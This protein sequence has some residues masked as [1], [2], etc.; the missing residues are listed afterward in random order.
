MLRLFV[1]EVGFAA[2]DEVVWRLTASVL[3]EYAERVSAMP[4]GNV[5]ALAGVPEYALLVDHG[6]A[7]VRLGHSPHVPDGALALS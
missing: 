4:G 5:P 2:A 6:D 1:S 7:L 3:R